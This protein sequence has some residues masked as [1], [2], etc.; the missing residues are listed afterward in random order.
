MDVD[1]AIAIQNVNARIDTHIH[2]SVINNRHKYTNSI[3]GVLWKARR[4]PKMEA[5]T[6]NPIITAPNNAA[7]MVKINTTILGGFDILYQ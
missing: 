6:M 3:I 4:T 2:V 7:R 5:T 1:V